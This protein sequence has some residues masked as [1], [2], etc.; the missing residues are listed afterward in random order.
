MEKTWGN[1]TEQEARTIR[2][3]AKKITDQ[4]IDERFQNVGDEVKFKIFVKSDRSMAGP[5]D[6]DLGEDVDVEE[7]L[8]AVPEMAASEDAEAI[9]M[10][11][12]ELEE[13]E[14]IEEWEVTLISPEDFDYEPELTDEDKEAEKAIDEDML[15][16]ADY[17]SA[18]PATRSETD[19]EASEMIASLPN[20]VDR[21]SAQS[22]VKNQ[23]RRGTCVAHA[24][25]GCLEAYRHIP[26]DL[27]EQY[28]HYKFNEFMGRPHNA[29]QGLKTTNAAIYLARSDG[30]ICE[31]AEWPYITQGAINS[32]VA[33][34][35]YAPP[36]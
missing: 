26:D 20:A 5:L 19:A 10:E 16:F 33:A 3:I 22:N 1:I 31:E 11:M 30:R 6:I 34:G 12:A 32:A 18:A 4:E 27:S 29:N 2:S 36:E 21:R 35:T 13:Q 17:F 8:R 28:L 24:S 7:A 14:E 23:G 15:Q 25:C 9:D